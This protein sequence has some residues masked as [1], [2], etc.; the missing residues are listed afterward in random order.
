MRR[1]LPLLIIATLSMMLSTCASESQAGIL[2]PQQVSFDSSDLERALDAGPSTATSGATS[3]SSTSRRT[4]HEWPPS[5]SDQPTNP[6]ELV[7]SSLPT[8]NSSSSTSTSS[9]GGAVGSGVVL[10]AFNNTLTL[11]DD[12]PLGQLA[13]DHGLALPEPPGTDLLRPPQA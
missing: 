11:R 8:S 12:S 1:V 10:C 4:S 5:D 9:A 6:L 2:L 13:E 3:S 7:K